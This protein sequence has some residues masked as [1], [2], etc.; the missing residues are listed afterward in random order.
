M[1]ALKC[2]DSVISSFHCSIRPSTTVVVDD[3][4]TPIAQR[5]QT[6]SHCRMLQRLSWV[7][8]VVQPD[9]GGVDIRGTAIPC[10]KCLFPG[11]S[12]LE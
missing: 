2:L 11:M 3:L 10:S 6:G 12:L 7:E 1:S 5:Y 9:L 8:P 4:L